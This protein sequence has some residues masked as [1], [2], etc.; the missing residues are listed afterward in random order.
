MDNERV[1][2]NKIIEPRKIIDQASSVIA[3][4]LPTKSKEVYEKEYYIF[5][6]WRKE[7]KCEGVSETIMLAYFSHKMKTAKSST[8]WS[9]YSKLKATISIKEN[10]DIS[11][12]IL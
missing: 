2:P 8:L 9:L 3:N 4:L 5:S 11:R 12:Y 6:D 10:I 7:N 1:F